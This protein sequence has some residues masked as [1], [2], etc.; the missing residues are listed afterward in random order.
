MA[1]W[2]FRSR[3][4]ITQNFPATSL[5]QIVALITFI[6]PKKK[7][8]KG[9]YTT[10]FR[11]GFDSSHLSPFSNMAQPSPHKYTVLKDLKLSSLRNGEYWYFNAVICSKEMRSPKHGGDYCLIFSIKDQSLDQFSIS[12]WSNK[13][14]Q[15]FAQVQPGD[16][17]RVH[18]A[19]VTKFKSR[20]YNHHNQ[21]A[22][23]PLQ[24]SINLQSIKTRFNPTG[25]N[26]AIFQGS[27]AGSQQPY[28]SSCLPA[29]SVD[30]CY[31]LLSLSLTHT[32]TLY[33]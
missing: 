28:F 16:I 27:S 29:V 5:F 2:K 22:N 18:H 17:L 33:V 10:T 14:P 3:S 12:I 1:S 4:K 30:N 6:K 13:V 21:N 15:F 11:E 8:R 24:C 9:V 32:H 20:A 23:L 26:F 31:W 19:K 25:C 7:T